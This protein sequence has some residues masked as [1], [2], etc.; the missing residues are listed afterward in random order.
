MN[1]L[2]IGLYL[3]ALCNADSI[4]IEFAVQNCTSNPCVN[5]KNPN[6]KI[7]LYGH[8]NTVD[9]PYGATEITEQAFIA[10]KIPFRLNLEYPDNPSSLIYPS[11]TDANQAEYYIVILWDSDGNG[12]AECGG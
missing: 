11:V 10:T 4:L 6:G 7:R 8:D 1:Q 5:I 2:L 9:S 3:F 12:Y